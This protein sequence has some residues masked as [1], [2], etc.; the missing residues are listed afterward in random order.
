MLCAVGVPTT[1]R[2]HEDHRHTDIAARLVVDLGHVVVDLVHTD[3]EEVSEHELDDRSHTLHGRAD[4]KA[5]EGGL[6]DGCVPNALRAE[7]V[8]QSGGG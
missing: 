3:A 8:E 1:S 7:G 2:H 4:A 6:R 5:D